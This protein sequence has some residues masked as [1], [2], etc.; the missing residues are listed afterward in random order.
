AGCEAVM[1]ARAHYVKTSTGF[2]EYG[3]RA[4]DVR[5]LRQTVGEAAG[6]KAAGGIRT[7]ADAWAMIAAGATRLGTS[8]TAAILDELA[9]Q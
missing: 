7:L 8:A 3:A 6:V 2:G 4:E 9:R 1:D 5:L